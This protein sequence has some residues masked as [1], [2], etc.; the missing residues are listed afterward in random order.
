MFQFSFEIYHSIPSLFGWMDYFS[1]QG[2][3]PS[4]LLLL[5]YYPFAPL[6]YSI[7]YLHF[8]VDI[9]YFFGADQGWFC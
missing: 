4:I 6:R 5:L 3:F 9:V 7:Q 2:I 8:D 1:A